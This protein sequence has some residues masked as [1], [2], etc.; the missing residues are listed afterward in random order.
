MFSTL[1]AMLDFHGQGSKAVVWAHNS[2]LGNAGA[3]DMSYRGEI[4]IGQLC[5]DQFGDKCYAIGMATH[6]GTVAAAAEWNGP[7]ETMKVVPSLPESY[8]RVLHDSEVPKFFLPLRDC[9]SLELRDRLSQPRLERAIGVIYKPDSER[10]SHYFNA[11][12]PDQFDELVWF[13]ETSAVTPLKTSELEGMP[14][15]Y[16]FGL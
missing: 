3:T 9:D 10:E 1:N 12:L 5:R 13:D 15:T 8:E 7:R 6:A 11:C 4:N 14:D 2:H 16:P